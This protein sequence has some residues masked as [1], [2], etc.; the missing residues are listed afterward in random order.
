MSPKASATSTR[1]F[2]EAASKYSRFSSSMS[3]NRS[4]FL[5]S[6]RSAFGISEIPNPNERWKRATELILLFIFFHFRLALRKNRNMFSKGQLIFAG[7]FAIVFAMVIFLSY[8][9]DKKLHLKNYKG[10]KWVGL[11]FIIFVIILFIIR[12]LLKN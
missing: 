5:S 1:S 2:L 9:K 3:P 4:L 8:K 7:L 12:T 6:P 11:S 10:V